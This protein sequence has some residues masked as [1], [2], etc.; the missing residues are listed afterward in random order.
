MTYEHIE[1]FLTVVV[2]GNISAASKKLFISQSTVSSRIQQLESEL[3][4]TLIMRQ[5]GHRNISLT[6]YGTAFV[7]I[8]S[9][10]AALW[11]DT[12]NLKATSDICTLRIASVD[13]VNNYTFVPLFQEHISSYPDI[14]L[15]I[16]THHSNE[17]Y[18]MV[19]NH[20][21]DL[22]F[23]FSQIAYPDV[24]T[25]PVYRELMYLLC[26]KDSPYGN[27]IACT[28]LDTSHEIYLNWGTDYKQWHDRH[29]SPDLYPLLQVNTGSMLQRYLNEPGR[30]GVAPMS[31]VQG[32]MRTNPDLTYY[33][34]LEPP[35]PR[36]C[37]EI[38]NRYPKSSRQ[39]AIATLEQELQSFIE[40]DSS[41][42]SFQTWMLGD[43]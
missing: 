39:D 24:I 15:S 38:K 31:V 4:T 33:S 1:T 27:N 35:A 11:K 2:C 25:I 37:Y 16:N 8:A 21:A 3:G 26:H 41:I 34:L 13:A 20:S 29:W 5:K 10:W 36:I 18:S 32:A 17:I 22:G 6:S 14:R 28:D 43:S 12:Q 23:V 30:W 40:R 9:Q 19:E 42:C 7:P